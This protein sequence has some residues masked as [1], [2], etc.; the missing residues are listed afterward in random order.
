MICDQQAGQLRDVNVL[1][2]DY[3][4]SASIRR[5]FEFLLQSVEIRNADA[6]IDR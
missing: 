1:P 3:K 2:R 4:K 6:G 5:K